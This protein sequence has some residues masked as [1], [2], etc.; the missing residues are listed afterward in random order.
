MS[1]PE[2][3]RVHGESMCTL[4]D[5]C[6]LRHNRARSGCLRRSPASIA[7]LEEVALAKHMALRTIRALLTMLLL[8]GCTTM[9]ADPA[10]TA[11]WQILANQATAHF[12]VAPVSVQPVAGHNSAYLCREGQIRLAIR[13][14]YVRFRLAHEL[15]HHVLHHCGTSYAQELDA[16]VVAIQVLQ[17][18]GLSE[19]DA[20]RET[21]VF[22]L[23]VKKFQ[24]NV[25]QPGHNVCGEAAALLRRYPSVPDPRMRGDRT[26]AE[27]FGGAKS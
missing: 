21:V 6:G 22:L 19:T 14:G 4:A 24:G 16:N 13:A 15:G 27:E 25:Q 7:A 5:E 1:R 3:R 10:E 20:V 9:V 23:E 18:W 26:C 17:L 2:D 11:K 12:R 8:A